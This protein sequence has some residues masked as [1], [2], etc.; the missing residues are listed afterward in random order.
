[1]DISCDPLEKFFG[2]GNLLEDIF[3]RENIKIFV[4]SFLTNF[5]S[6]LKDI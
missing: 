6:I 5:K 1:M 4:I 3:F 2:V